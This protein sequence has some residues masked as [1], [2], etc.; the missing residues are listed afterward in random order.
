MTN[1]KFWWVD[2]G[3]LPSAI[4][5]KVVEVEAYFLAEEGG[6]NWFVKENGPYHLKGRPLLLGSNVFETKNEAIE[7][8]IANIIREKFILDERIK[9]LDSLNKH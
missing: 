8:A 3:G 2:M 5:P 6:G 4:P 7:S 9:I 1:K